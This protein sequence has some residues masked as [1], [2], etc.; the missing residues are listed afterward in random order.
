MKKAPEKETI[1]TYCGE[2]IGQKWIPN[3]NAPN[4]FELNDFWWVCYTCNEIIELQTTLSIGCYM[5][6]VMK[7]NSV[8][9]AVKDIHEKNIEVAKKID[10]V[11]REAG[12]TTI[13]MMIRRENEQEIKEKK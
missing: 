12:M 11:A 5:E 7:K 4:E 13:S 10:N 9:N 3:P 2:N 8:G 1:C 6:E